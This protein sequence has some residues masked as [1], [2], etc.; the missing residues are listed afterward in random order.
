MIWFLAALCTCLSLHAE[1]STIR[2]LVACDTTSK[3][4]KI[5]T[6]LDY[7]RIKKSFLHIAQQ[8]KIPTKIQTLAGK[9]FS[10]HKIK[11]WI[12][13]LQPSDIVL[14]YYSGHGLRP[15]NHDDPWPAIPYAKK[16]RKYI[17]S[18]I[19]SLKKAICRK[20]PRFAL[21]LLDC[22]NNSSIPKSASSLPI[23]PFYIPKKSR[24]PGLR[25]LFLE[26]R[27]IITACAAAPGE[28]A[29]AVI[30]GR[31]QG[32]IFSV[33]FIQALLAEGQKNL[34]SWKTILDNTCAFSQRRS[35]GR[36][37]PVYSIETVESRQEN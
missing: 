15:R 1:Q 24:L 34:A 22:C 19:S 37:H 5:G 2:A 21:F 28:A 36:Q 9:R 3:D 10:I 11:E 17:F 20:N 27:G 13:D 25:P 7:M 4:I 29:L 6:E 23:N 16:R 18:P 26:T 8:L 35:E 30:G 14:F 32:S 33:H 12:S 31:R